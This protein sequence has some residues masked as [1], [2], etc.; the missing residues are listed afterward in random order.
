M[1][2]GGSVFV[3]AS[4]RL[5]FGVLDLRGEL[6]RRF[7]GMGAAVPEPSLLLEVAPDDRLW[8]EGPD[9]ARAVAFAEQFL[10]HHGLAGGA[11]LTVHRSIP[12]HSGLGSG[13]V[14]PILRRLEAAGL[15]R[16]T[17][18]RAREAQQAGRPP[19]RY[20]AVTRAG[21]QALA[22][23]LDRYPA[24]AAALDLPRGVPR[25]GFA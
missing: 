2:G 14:Y 10:S 22:A 16:G 13:T 1:S 25:P 21:A 3:E 18:E 17:A 5:H 9:S 24:A 15:L 12:A 23:A 8:A 20:Y 11:R 19:R 4:A 7:G 6:G